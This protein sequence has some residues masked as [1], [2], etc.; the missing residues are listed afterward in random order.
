MTEAAYDQIG[1]TYAKTRQADPRIAARIEEALK[2]AES[3]V[4]VGAGAGSYEPTDLH[5]IP[6]EPS[7][8]MISQRRPGAAGA[9]LGSAERL[10]LPDKVAEAAMAILSIHHWDDPQR[11]VWEMRRVARKRVVVLTYDPDR[12]LGWWLRDYAPQIAADDAERFPA[13][14]DLLNWLGGGAIE[15]VEVPSDCSDLFL[16]ALWARPELVLADQVRASTSG[17][18]RM[19]DEEEQ[20]AV[21]KLRADL[22]SGAWEERYGDLRELDELDVGLRLVACEFDR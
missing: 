9:I 16:G 13:L 11:G 10:P 8:E 15:T 18:A 7:R 14:E 21:I 22:A 6:V 20:A 17:F 19:T 1:R 4:N 5:V 2:D 12:A 3:L